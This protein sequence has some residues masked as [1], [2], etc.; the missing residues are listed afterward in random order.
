MSLTLGSTRRRI[1]PYQ[2]QT[3]MERLQAK[4]ALEKEE[5]HQLARLLNLS[6]SYITNWFRRTHPKETGEKLHN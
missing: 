2:K 3:L 4:T 6:Q 5:K 1:N